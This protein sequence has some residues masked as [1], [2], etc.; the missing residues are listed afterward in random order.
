[1]TSFF[2]FNPKKTN[3]KQKTL[4]NPILRFWKRNGFFGVPPPP[5]P[6]PPK[7]KHAG[8]KLKTWTV[9]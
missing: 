2:K 6:P 8:L 1:M 7:Y 5:P 3:N 4:K 9:L